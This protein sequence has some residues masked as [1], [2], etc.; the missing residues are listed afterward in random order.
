MAAER[1]EKDG[2]LAASELAKSRNM[3]HVQEEE[4]DPFEGTPCCTHLDL[5]RDID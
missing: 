5:D 1:W 2:E 4:E 3:H